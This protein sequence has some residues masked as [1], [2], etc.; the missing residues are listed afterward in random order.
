MKRSCGSAFISAASTVNPP[1]PESNT[2]MGASTAPI[3]L[4]FGPQLREGNHIA[5][6]RRIGEEHHQTVDADAEASRRRHAV[7]QGTYIVG[8]VEHR[9][10]IALVL[11]RNLRRE[12]RGLIL[13][14]IELGE[15]VGEFAAREKELKA[16]GD[17]GILVIAARQ[18]R[19]LHGVGIYKGG[20]QQRLLDG[21][22]ENLDLQL[23]GAVAIAERNGQPVT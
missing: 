9:L 13:R 6:R 20:I 21:L 12:A 7:F 4:G 16:I 23:A 19:H 10:L 18:R 15:A 22:L 2:P 11:A 5:D 17:E 1:I 14:V 8:V 3:A